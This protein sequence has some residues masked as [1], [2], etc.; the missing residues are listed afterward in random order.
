[1]SLSLLGYYMIFDSRIGQVGDRMQLISPL[2]AISQ[3]TQLQ[4]SYYISR[5]QPHG[6]S[7]LQ[8]FQVSK[9]G[10]K[11]Q[12]LFENSMSVDT[13]WQLATVCLPIGSYSLVFLGTMGNPVVSNIAVDSIRVTRSNQCLLVSRPTTNSKSGKC[14]I[15]RPLSAV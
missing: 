4:F 7:L 2:M 10:I 14:E 5:S 9:L 11:V 15:V 6:G 8:L 1:V 13:T 3:S 12:L